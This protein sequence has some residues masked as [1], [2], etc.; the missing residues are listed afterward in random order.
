MISEL[1]SLFGALFHLFN[2][3]TLTVNLFCPSTLYIING[4][5]K[6]KLHAVHSLMEKTGCTY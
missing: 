2:K 4:E 3:I 1:F 6:D 5:M